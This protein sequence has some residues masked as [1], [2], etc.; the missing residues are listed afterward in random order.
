M[1]RSER[2]PLNI[3]SLDSTKM[4]N[5][6]SEI[7]PKSAVLAVPRKAALVISGFQSA[8]QYIASEIYS[9]H[10]SVHVYMYVFMRI[11]SCG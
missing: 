1:P 2:L 8:M 4:A 7:S 9:V 3:L 6:N 11:Y 10:L 5:I